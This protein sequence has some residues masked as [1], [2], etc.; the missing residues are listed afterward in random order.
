MKIGKFCKT[1]NRRIN[2]RKKQER[3]RKAS[4][5]KEARGVLKCDEE[6]IQ[7]GLRNESK[8]DTVRKEEQNN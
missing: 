7:E 2:L 6:E 8:T 4:D 1:C 3:I 5:E